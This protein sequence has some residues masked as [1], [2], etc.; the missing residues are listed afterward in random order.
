MTHL[1]LYRSCDVFPTIPKTGC[2]LYS[3]EISEGGYPKNGP[4]YYGIKLLVI[5]GA[6]FLTNSK[7]G[8]LVIAPKIRKSK[9]SAEQKIVKH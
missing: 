2:R 8:D 5:H 7:I 3:H 4:A 6:V 9:P 1:K